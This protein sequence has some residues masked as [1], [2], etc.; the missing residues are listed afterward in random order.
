MTVSALMMLAGSLA[1][2]IPA[3]QTSSE[4]AFPVALRAEGQAAAGV[5]V[6]SALAAAASG[7][8]RACHM[9]ILDSGGAGAADMAVFE[10]TYR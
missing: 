10:V 2:V 5:A 7:T 4:R 8:Q 9:Q 3:G 1:A 6:L